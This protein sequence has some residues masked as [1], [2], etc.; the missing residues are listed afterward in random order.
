MHFKNVT[1]NNT[2]NNQTPK[3]SNYFNNFSSNNSSK[4][5]GRKQLNKDTFVGKSAEIK[6]IKDYSEEF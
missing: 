5:F 3:T 6:R 1:N 4:D 2:F